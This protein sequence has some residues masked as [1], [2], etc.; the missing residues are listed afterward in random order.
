MIDFNQIIT[1]NYTVGVVAV[2]LVV[3]LLLLSRKK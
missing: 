1:S 2:V 3:L